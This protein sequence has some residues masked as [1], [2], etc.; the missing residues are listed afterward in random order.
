MKTKKSIAL[1]SAAIIAG[2]TVRVASADIVAQWS[3]TATAAQGSPGVNSPAAT[4]G[5]NASSSSAVTLGMNNNYTYTG[6]ETTPTNASDDIVSTTASSIT[7]DTWRVRG[8]SNTSGMPGNGWNNSA[9]N[10]TQGA[11]FAIP[12]TGY[13]PTS[14]SFDWYST[15]QAPANLQVAYTLDDTAGAGFNY[16]GDEGANP[17]GGLNPPGVADPSIAWTNLGSDY[18]I[19]AGSI[20]YSNSSPN[21]TIDLT[22]LPAGATN[23][24]NFAIELVSV[25]PTLGDADYTAYV[26]GDTSGGQDY[27]AASG[28]D[29]NN[30]SGNWRFDNITL[31]GTAVP[32]P[33]SI[34]LL[35]LAG[36]AL[37]N[38]RR[39]QKTK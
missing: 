19:S 38:R 11:A 24:P 23:D 39:T 26:T 18:V 17:P 3:F 4:G 21:I 35:G 25:R 32:E 8:T 9:P 29:Y 34:G 6:G 20:F 12:T 1:L 13:A 15:N 10:Y 28:G 27:W 36:L 33:A 2:M 31:S 37:L 16:T 5:T 22:G 7:E 30:N 14:F